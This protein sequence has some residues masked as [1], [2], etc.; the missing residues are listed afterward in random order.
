MPSY[1]SHDNQINYI[2]LPV[3][4]L[5]GTKAFFADVFGWT[6]TD[7]GEAYCSIDNAGID[8]GFYQVSQP[9]TFD[10]YRVD[11]AAP[12]IILYH[13]DLSATIEKIERAGG[14]IIRDTFSFPGGKRFHFAD[15]NNNEYAVW[16]E[17]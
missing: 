17:D 14:R 7:Y 16:C 5:A 8:G 2:E 4:D 6:F 3:K 10:G 15:I 12:L 9:D 1:P 11:N 13:R